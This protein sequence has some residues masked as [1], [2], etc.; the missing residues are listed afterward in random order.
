[1]VVLPGNGKL[2]WVSQ[3]SQ[4]KNGVG[5]GVGDKPGVFVLVGVTVFVGVLVGV[6][7][8]VGGGIIESEQISIKVP[9]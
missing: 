6:L 5:V 7:L 4:G 9:P 1:M 8:G 3:L 2:A